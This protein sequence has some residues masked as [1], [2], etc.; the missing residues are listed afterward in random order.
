[1]NNIKLKVVLMLILIILII[2]GGNKVFAKYVFETSEF[3]IVETNLDRTPPKLNITYSKTDITNGNV[4]VTIKSNERIK[5]VEGWTI[6]EDKQILTKIYEANKTENIEVFDLAG[7]KSVANI[8]VNNIDKVI[9]IVECIEIN[10]SNSNYPLYANSEKEINL[11]IKVTDNIEIK[12]INLDKINIKVGNNIANLTKE[13]TLKSSN[14]KEKIYNLK[15]KNV[16]GDGILTVTIENGFVTDIANNNNIKKDVNTQIAIDNTKP[17]ITYSQE[18]ISQGKVNA[19]LTANE[20]VQNLNGWNLSADSKKLNKNFTSNTT[21][22]TVITDYAGNNA[23]ITV[24]ISGATY[25]NLT[26]ASHNSDVGWTFGHGNYDIAGEMA[27]HKN[28]IYKTEALAFNINGNIEKD[29]LKAKAYV[30]TH[31][32]EGSYGRCKDTGILYNFGYSQYKT[33]NSSDLVT[34]EN[35][36]CFQFGGTG[37]NGYT[38]TDTNGNNAIPADIAN[39]F[40]YGICGL[41]LELKDYSEYSIVYQIYVSEVGWI[42]AVS[43]GKETMYSKTKPISAFRVTFIPTSEKESQLSTWN[44]DIGKKIN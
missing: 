22:N 3:L 17:N 42:E 25:I 24:D 1:M 6:S 8:K 7:N 41:T 36:K 19:I 9:P 16:K 12:D 38:H 30:Y 27:V 28:P 39:Q 18:I 31:W 23:T 29:F 11:T 13:W 26:Y 44:K 4:V 15:L 2:L 32:G 33:M 10:N 34:L 21:Y 37:I 40:R 20:K 5:D 43:N 35:K 14:T